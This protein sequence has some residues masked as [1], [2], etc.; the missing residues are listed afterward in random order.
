[1][2]LRPMQKLQISSPISLNAIEQFATLLNQGQRLNQDIVITVMNEICGTTAAEGG[3]NW[4]E[5]YN[6][7]EAAFVRVLLDNPDFQDFDALQGLV[8]H[9]T[10]RSEQQ[11]E[12][13]QFST[14]LAL[15]NIAAITAQMT[16]DD[17]VLEPSA[18]TGILAGFAARVTRNLILNEIC[19]ERSAILGHLFPHLPIYNYN[20]EQIDDYL[21]ASTSHQPTVVLMNP[22]FS[23]SPNMAKRNRQAVFSHIRSAIDRLADA[24][25]LV[26]IAPHW[27]NPEMCHSFTKYPAQLL[28]SAYIPGK[29]YRYHATTM[30][31]RLL[32]FD[33]IENSGPVPSIN[34]PFEEMLDIVRALPHRQPITAAR[35]LATNIT[36]APTIP[37]IV[38]STDANRDR[39]TPTETQL[40]LVP[41]PA[42]RQVVQAKSVAVIPINGFAG[43]VLL[44]YEAAEVIVESTDS[45]GIY[46][47]YKSSSIKI[48]GAIEHPTPLVESMAMASVRM[49]VPTYQPLLPANLVQQGILSHAQLEAIVFAGEAHSQMLAAHWYFDPET[50]RISRVGA[51]DGSQYRRGFWVGDGTGVGKGREASGIF[52]DNW[53]QG[54]RK[55]LWLSKNPT[56]LEDSRRDWQSLGGNPEQI[57]PIG[58]YKQGDTI[59]LTEGILFVPY[60]TLRVGAKQGKQSRL[61]QIIDWLGADFDGCICFDEAHM[62]GN[63]MGDEGSRGKKAAS[64]Q[65]LAGLELQNRLPSAR[66]VYISATGASKVSNLAYASRLGLWQTD[67]FPFAS[68]EEFVFN[69]ECSG[70]AAMEVVIRDLKSLG[71]YMARALSYDGIA[72]ETMVHNLTPEQVEIYGT[73]AKAFQVIHKNIDAALAATN[74]VSQSGQCRN[75]NSKSAARSAF[76]GTKQRFFNHLVTAAKFP[77]VVNALESDLQAGHA[78]ILQIVATDEALLERRLAEIPSDQWNDMRLDFTP[79]EAIID[80]LMHSF[81]VQLQ[82]VYTDQEGREC[83]RLITDE[84]GNPILC[85]AAVAMRERLIEDIALLPS[86]AGFLDQLIWHFG[87]DVV[88]EVT[89]R[90]KRVVLKDGKYQLESR[91]VNA[92]IAETQ[93]FQDDRKKILV[94]SAAGGTGRSYHADLKATNQR[95]R[96]H[97]LIQ[98]GWEASNAVQSLG[99]SHR[100][101]QKQPPVFILTTTNVKGEVRF[102]ATIASRLASL[103]ALT[104]GQRQTG[105]QGIYNEEVSNLTSDYAKATLIDFFQKFYRAGIAGYS[106]AEFSEITG[107]NLLCQEGGLRDDLPAI[108]TFLN[109]LLALAIKDQNQLFAVFEDMLAI[110]IQAAKDSGHFEVGVERLVADGGFNILGQRVLA[111]HPG[112]SST[113]CHEIERLTRPRVLTTAKAREMREWHPDTTGCIVHNLGQVALLQVWGERTSRDGNVITQSELITPSGVDKID[114][115]KL[116]KL[117]WSHTK[118]NDDFWQRWEREVAEIPEYLSSKLYLICGLLLP[119]W[120]KLPDDRSKV[121][122]LQANDGTVLLGRSAS[123]KELQKIYANFGVDAPELS[124]S[125]IYEAIWSNHQVVA[126]GSWQLRRSYWKG[127]DYLEVLVSGRE[128]VEYLKSLGCLTEMVKFTM[129]VYVPRNDQMMAVLERLKGS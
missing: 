94:F 72:Y 113:I 2:E 38:V 91:S 105:S 62:M 66:I 122:R 26:A 127:D 109:R 100:S 19:P 37:K 126:V 3:W 112:G 11:I 40:I 43:A 104:R 114:D 70:I 17:S 98:S 45:E 77:T 48:Q 78:P 106:I 65:G 95:L 25:R 33:K 57:V 22:P 63:A 107:L 36:P 120:D 90:S 6:L 5:A 125:E 41:P 1:M 89:G 118:P 73:Y 128:R 55:G 129:R 93:A 35:L 34:T 42:S 50:K 8:P 51:K 4:K 99:R 60:G 86:V 54:R 13:Q 24:G 58:K 59:G 84:M 46:E 53:M 85:K 101:S 61:D 88:A 111:T 64:Q 56:L 80:Y 119:I 15:A 124:I 39:R 96:R 76:E 115:Y 47:P 97:Y 20:A 116:A 44:V 16:A 123:P 49:P 23:A 27:F 87:T 92:N 103:G 68:R 102:T 110:R 31:T 28:L 83:S 74:A 67:H 10:V 12:L 21:E 29:V 69:L 82:E 117:G 79:K 9:Q 108:N 14:P 81:P 71:L 52:C 121:H 7:I 18:G 75:S 30:E 32:V